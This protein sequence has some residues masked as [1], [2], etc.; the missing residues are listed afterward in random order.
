MLSHGYKVHINTLILDTLD[1]LRFTYRPSR[2]TAA[3]TLQIAVP[4]RS[5][6]TAERRA[7]LPAAERNSP[8]QSAVLT[9]DQSGDMMKSSG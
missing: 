7:Q 1:L 9:G 5:V 6:K 3:N 4:A 8:Q 2:S